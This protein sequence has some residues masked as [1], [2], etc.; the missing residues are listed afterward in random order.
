MVYCLAPEC[1]VAGS[2]ISGVSGV[3]VS[4]R[5]KNVI[6]QEHNFF[7]V[8]MNA[9]RNGLGWVDERDQRRRALVS[10]GSV[11]MFECP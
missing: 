9:M 10:T 11:A 4:A 5:L 8:A 2:A 1:L 3:G 6:C 7:G